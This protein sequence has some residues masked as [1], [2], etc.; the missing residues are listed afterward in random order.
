MTLPTFPDRLRLSRDEFEAKIINIDLEQQFLAIRSNYQSAQI[1]RAER[2]RA[3]RQLKRFQHYRD[4]I[5]IMRYYQ[6]NEWS[7]TIQFEWLIHSCTQ[8]KLQSLLLLLDAQPLIYLI[9]STMIRAKSK[10][11]CSV[12]RRERRT[13][14]LLQKIATMSLQAN[15]DLELLSADRGMD[16]M[17]AEL[18]LSSER[19]AIFKMNKQKELTTSMLRTIQQRFPDVQMGQLIKKGIHVD[20]I[21]MLQSINAVYPNAFISIPEGICVR[22]QNWQAEEVPR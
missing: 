20:L 21:S 9:P 22:P 7:T 14:L 4:A 15:L 12:G 6:I 17:Q 8:K 10:L 13:L 11:V 18:T 5:E 16:T 3:V 2:D 1:S 19:K